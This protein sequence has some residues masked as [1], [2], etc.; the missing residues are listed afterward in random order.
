MNDVDTG[1]PPTE[2][3]RED[4]FVPSDG[5][6]GGGTRVH[7]TF[8]VIPEWSGRVKFLV[9]DDVIDYKIF[10]AVLE[11]AGL[12]V[13]VGRFRRRNGGDKGMF[14]VDGDIEFTNIKNIE[15][16]EGILNQ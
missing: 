15:D 14:V 9:T 12:N 5:K 10:K 1:V 16:V 13:G 4:L 6:T 3:V 2:V 8:P 7:K 11:N